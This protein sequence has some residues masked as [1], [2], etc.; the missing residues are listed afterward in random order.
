MITPSMTTKDGFCVSPECLLALLI[1]HVQA[2]KHD[3][4]QAEG[5]R[6]YVLVK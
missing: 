2:S 6:I 5:V 4:E 3:S 1:C